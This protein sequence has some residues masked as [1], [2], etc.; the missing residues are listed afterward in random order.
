[1]V[2]LGSLFK[3][4]HLIAN[5]NALKVFTRLFGIFVLVFAC[6]SYISNVEANN[7]ELTLKELGNES[8][9]KIKIAVQSLGKLGNPTAL[10]AL[11]ALKNKRL[12]VTD[13]GQLVILNELEDQ[14]VDALTG[15]KLDIESLTLRKPRIN[16]S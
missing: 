10:P 5:S 11:N 1:M 16:N 13:E 8:R 9:S 12:A 2:N 4:S 6:M 15:E 7:F 14:G 3:F